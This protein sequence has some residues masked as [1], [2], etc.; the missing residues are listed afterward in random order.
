MSGTQ[1]YLDFNTWDIPPASFVDAQN[2]DDTTGVVGDGNKPFR[3]V[4]FAILQSDL[5]IIKPC[6]MFETILLNSP[7]E[8]NKHIHC[9]AGVEF[10]SGGLRVQTT[11][12]TNVRWTGQAIFTGAFTSLVDCITTSAEIDFEC[13]YASDCRLV[14]FSSGDRSQTPTVRFKAN[15]IRCN[16]FNGGGYAVR[17]IG[18][19]DFQLDIKE[20]FESQHTIYEMRDNARGR[21]VVNCP[22]SIIIPNYTISYGNLNKSVLRVNQ[23]SDGIDVTINGDLIQTHDVAGTGLL[24]AKA[25]VEFTQNTNDVSRP[26][27]VIN[28]NLDNLLSPCV[29]SGFRSKY[30]D[31]AVY[32]NLIARNTT[33][34]FAGSPIWKQLS[35]GLGVD[36]EQQTWKFVGSTI[37]GSQRII[38][39]RGL[40]AYFLNG[41]IYN[42]DAGG[43]ESAFFCEQT[44]TVLQQLYLYNMYVETDNTG[45]T[46]E[47]V[48][49]NSVGAI[50][51][52]V[53]TKANVAFGLTYV[54]IW[55]N[56]YANQPALIVPQN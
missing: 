15:W 46:P 26:N 31:L 29:V 34:G 22:R 38:I 44:G 39:G 42:A 32:G 28:G 25:C 24:D 37:V 10:V 18:G 6:T 11:N 5:V 50:I 35:G 3:T 1:A 19:A 48:K 55:G 49:G 41:T 16:C 30:G 56:D 47:L 9:M 8:N 23:F 43:S 12:I 4:A 7:A 14:V 20:F 54:D 17:V 52:T 13:D 21:L 45:V 40:I 2:G 53:D 27:V 51:G 36:P 33:G